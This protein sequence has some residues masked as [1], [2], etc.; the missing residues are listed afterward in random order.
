MKVGGSKIFYK[1]NTDEFFLFK[2]KEE[3][4]NKKDYFLFEIKKFNPY[5]KNYQNVAMVVAKTFAEAFEK[6]IP[7]VSKF[8][9]KVSDKSE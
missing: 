8:K 9:I 1:E 5:L 3:I 4:A 7:S 2:I 6:Q